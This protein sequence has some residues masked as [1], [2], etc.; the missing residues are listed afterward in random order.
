MDLQSVFPLS[1]IPLSPSEFRSFLCLFRSGLPLPTP[2]AL[3]DGSGSI[4]A[5]R[6]EVGAQGCPGPQHLRV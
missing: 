2:L 5:A 1:P 3:S 4:V 6:K